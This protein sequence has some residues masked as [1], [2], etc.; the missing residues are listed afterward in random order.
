MERREGQEQV[1]TEEVEEEKRGGGGTWGGEEEEDEPVQGAGEAVCDV[2]KQ[3][4]RG[5]KLMLTREGIQEEY[6]SEL[7]HVRCH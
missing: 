5:G 3:S 4:T 7:R 6:C 1:E 2:R